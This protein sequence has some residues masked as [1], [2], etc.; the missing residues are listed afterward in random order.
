MWKKAIHAESQEIIIFFSWCQKACHIIFTRNNTMYGL[1][2]PEVQK[3][4]IFWL[5]SDLIVH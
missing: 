1:R 2:W 5:T 4:A 3:V